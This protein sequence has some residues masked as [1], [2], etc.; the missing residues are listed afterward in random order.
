MKRIVNILLSVLLFVS[1]GFFSGKT[2]ASDKID[3]TTFVLPKPQPLQ[4]YLF[5]S[6]PESETEYDALAM[7]YTVDD[8]VAALSANAW[9]QSDAFLERNGLQYFGICL[10]YDVSLDGEE[11]WQ[12][13]PEWDLQYYAGSFSHGYSSVP[14]SD[15]AMNAFEFFWLYY[16][17]GEGSDTFV[18]YQPAIITKQ[19][20]ND[21]GDTWNTYHF[22]IENHS[23]YTRC[24]YYMEWQTVD[25]LTNEVSEMQHSV[26][27]WSDSTVIDRNSAMAIPEKPV[28][29]DAPVISDLQMLPPGETQQTYD[30]SYF[31]ST[32]QSVW[33]A[34]MYYLM[35]NDGGFDGLKTQISINGGD[36]QDYETLDSFGDLGLNNGRRYANGQL[37]FTEDSHIRLRV[38]YIGTQGASEWSNILELNGNATN[39]KTEAVSSSDS[40]DVTTT[41]TVSTPISPEN[42]AHSL[43][44]VFVWVIAILAL[45]LLVV[46]ILMVATKK[47]I[48]PNCNTKCKKQ[49]DTCPKCG[50]KLSKSE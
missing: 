16:H 7:I 30:L 1:L 47:H 14:L 23:L 15:V 8:T 40:N 13:H 45:I 11:N 9:S 39:L 17:Q 35:T 18:P 10:Q 20:Q 26:G 29:Y 37:A 4:F 41:T 32:P 25:P 21:N 36:W 19:H 22:D 12:Y 2:H 6:E 27:P 38:R 24:R 46:V 49:A 44:G 42:E 34:N 43:S 48:C 33:T 5:E 28:S 50:R 3:L 31:L